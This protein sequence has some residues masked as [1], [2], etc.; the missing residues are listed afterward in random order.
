MKDIVALLAGLGTAGLIG[1]LAQRQR[2]SPYS[3]VDLNHASRAALLGL[4][5]VDDEVAERI[6]EHRPY[7]SKL[8]LLAQMVVSADVY[9][10]IKDR[11]LADGS[12]EHVKVAG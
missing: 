7:R 5:G 4:A 11:I 12:D 2:R 9:R 8:D 10:D 1:W 3:L 6:E